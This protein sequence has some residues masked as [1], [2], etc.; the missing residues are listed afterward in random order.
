MDLLAVAGVSKAGKDKHVLKN[1]TFSQEQ[2]EK[3]VIAGETGSGK[4]TLL[5]IIAG[6]VQPDTGSIIF[7]QKEVAGPL[8][9]LIPG[10]PGISYLSQHFELPKNLRVEQVLGYSNELTASTAELLYRVCKIDHLLERKTNELSGGE[11]QRIALAKLLITSPQLLLLDEPYSNLDMLHKSILKSV[12]SDIS[13]KLKITCIL[14]SH[15]P[16]DTLSWADR[17]LVMKDGEIIQAASPENIYKTP[18]NEYVAALF[19]KYNLL[20][21]SVEKL[22]NQQLKTLSNITDNRAFIRPEEFI[23]VEKG[24]KTLEGIVKSVL[25]FGAY[26]QIEVVVADTTI[27]AH[28]RERNLKPGDQVYLALKL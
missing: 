28:H 27:Y 10:H 5:K 12:L 11:K 14:V 20:N 3:I 24:E 6:L 23:L 19:G 9:K 7:D 18:L 13:E 22:L 17:I 15:D 8:D 1:I 4:S 2:G 16:H 21:G 25:F 26:Y